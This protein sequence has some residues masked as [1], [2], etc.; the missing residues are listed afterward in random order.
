MKIFYNIL[1]QNI[2][3]CQ[4]SPRTE[5]KGGSLQQLLQICIWLLQTSSPNYLGL[6]YKRSLVSL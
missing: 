4:D 5:I 2:L 3:I 6:G 1:L